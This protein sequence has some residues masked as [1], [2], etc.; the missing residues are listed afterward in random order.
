MKLLSF[1]VG[2][3]NLA[4]CI[5]DTTECKIN[6]WEVI[7][8]D[9]HASNYNKLYINLITELDKRKFML[10]TNVV[11]IEKQPSFNPKMR[12]VAGCLQTYFFI[13]GIV[14]RPDKKISSVEFFSPKH[15]LKCYTGPE[16]V[17][18]SKNKSK[19]SQTKKMGVLI[20]QSKMEEFKE[21][22][23]TKAIFNNS[24]K[25][26]DLSDCYL[27]AITYAIFK[28]AL[29]TT[30]QPYI[31]N[32]QKKLTK[33]QLK[34]QLKEILDKSVKTVSVVD[35][36]QQVDTNLLRV[37]N[38]MDQLI[39]DELTERYLISFPLTTQEPFDKFLSDLSMKRYSTL[40]FL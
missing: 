37:V 1:D 22:P 5:F 7:T 30:I 24:K 33:P 40:H 36:L 3:V 14:D 32:V 26:D 28:K 6:Y 29:R 34:K 4:Y 13:R 35:R 19:Y 23:E 16:L 25:K 39:K 38:T 31:E 17:L 2:I 11:L 9:N 12:I 15:K 8:L 18:E 10:E 27:Q 20:A 21:T